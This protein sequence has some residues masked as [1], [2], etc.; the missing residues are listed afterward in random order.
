MITTFSNVLTFEKEIKTIKKEALVLRHYVDKKRGYFFFKRAFDIAISSLFTMLV[1]S[2]LIPF[3]AVL[4]RL[5]SRGPV[6][7]IQKRVGRG[8]RTFRCLKFRTMIVNAEA[9]TTQAR[10]NDTRIT[11]LGKFL[12]TSNLDELPQFINVLLG[13][14]SIVGP[15]PHM[16][17]DCCKFSAVVAGYKFRN[18]V[19]PGIT[20]LAQVKGFRGPTRDFASI[21]HRYQFDAFYVRNANFWLD[22][23]IIRQTAGQTIISLYRRLFPVD[24]SQTST[25]PFSRKW[26]AALRSPRN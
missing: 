25:H 14:M 13:H 16:H 6:F 20:G 8:G 1:L 19:R 12:R 23:R 22:M 2:W 9:N 5:D 4:I 10:E 11:R 15:R 3:I 7:F 26:I 17:S 21:F 24:H 18:M